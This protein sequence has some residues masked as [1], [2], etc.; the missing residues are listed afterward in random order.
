MVSTAPIFA[1]SSQKQE[2]SPS[3]T[4]GRPLSPENDIA[5][6]IIHAR[7]DYVNQEDLMKAVRKVGDA[8]KHECMSLDHFPKSSSD[9]LHSKT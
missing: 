5:V 9:P 6:L 4:R 1:M 7:R 8:K 3:G 2:C